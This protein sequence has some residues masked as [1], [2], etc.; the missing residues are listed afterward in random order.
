[1]QLEIPSCLRYGPKSFSLQGYDS[2]AKISD[3]YQLT[4][5]SNNHVLMLYFVIFKWNLLR[6]VVFLIRVRYADSIKKK[7]KKKQKK[8]DR[9]KTLKNKETEKR[10]IQLK[11]N[12]N[13]KHL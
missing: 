13:N 11:S 2:K 9:K 8:T 4:L 7:K 1:M 10:R 3:F 6:I 12:S 5:L